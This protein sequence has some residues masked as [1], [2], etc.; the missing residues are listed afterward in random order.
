MFNSKEDQEQAIEEARYELIKNAVIMSGTKVY[1]EL[2]TRRFE[3][4]NRIAPYVDRAIGV[5]ILDKWKH[6]KN[7][8]IEFYHMST[9]EFRFVWSDKDNVDNI[10]LIDALFIDAN[11]SYKQSLQD[12]ENFSPFV[13]LNGLIFL[14]DSYPPEE[15]YLDDKWCGGVWKTAKMIRWAY[16]KKFEIVT[17]PGNFGVSIIRKASK[18]LLWRD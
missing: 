6:L 2:G 14:H 10:T 11:H 18:Q 15:K 1:V 16:R 5:D 3:Q 4:I 8:G 17:I 9:D 12:F 7:S 13:K